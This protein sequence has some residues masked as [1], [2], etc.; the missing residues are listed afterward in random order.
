MTN[1]EL[2][3]FNKKRKLVQICYVTR[4]YKK[5]IKN[6]LDY[7][8]VGPWTILSLSDKTTKNVKIDNKLI[9]EP[10]EFFVAFS[11][12]GD[13]QIE[14]I[15][16]VTGPSAYTKFLEEKGEG[17]HHIKEKVDDVI[18]KKVLDDYKKKGIDVIF[19]GQF[20]IDLFYYLDMESIIGSIYELGN[21]PVINLPKKM[22]SIYPEE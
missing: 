19:S 3:L 14:V 21:S 8:N 6:W 5:T 12:I 15:Q 10:F 16:P 20:D 13:M 17:I 4:D 1:K 7:L 18:L 11:Y 2:L 22:F 9:K